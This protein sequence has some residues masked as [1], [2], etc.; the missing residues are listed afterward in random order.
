MIKGREKIYYTDSVIV[1]V[2]CDNCGKSLANEDN[3]IHRVRNFI[4]IIL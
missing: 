1:D 4:I 2:F 3:F